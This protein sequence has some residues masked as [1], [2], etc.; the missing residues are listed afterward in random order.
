MAFEIG[1]LNMMLRTAIGTSKF[2]GVP[3]MRNACGGVLIQ[4]NDDPHMGGCQI[5]GPFVD[6]YYNTPPIIFRVPKKGQ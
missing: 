1:S 5:Y 2:S 3:S 4:R 6:P